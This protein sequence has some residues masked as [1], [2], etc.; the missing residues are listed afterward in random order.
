MSGDNRTEEKK[1]EKNNEISR[2]SK[3]NR[4]LS[5]TSAMVILIVVGALE[6]VAS[7]DENMSMLDI[8]GREVD[9][10]QFSALS[11]RAG[12]LRKALDASD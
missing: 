8:K 9:R 10:V 3:R 12:I 6:A 7:L 4:R 1:R 2:P 11:G 5:N